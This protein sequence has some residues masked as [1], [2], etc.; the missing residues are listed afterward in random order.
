MPAKKPTNA[1]VAEFEMLWPILKALLNETKELS[2]KKADNPLN[3]LKVGMINKVLERVKKLLATDPTIQFLELLDDETLPSNSDAVFIIAQYDAAM[4]QYKDKH[5]G[6][7]SGE[8][9]RW[10]TSD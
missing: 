1:Q 5:Y 3:K 7:E 8:G 4:E 9:H 2:K 10:F 6:Y